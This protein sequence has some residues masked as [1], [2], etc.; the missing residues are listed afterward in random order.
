MEQQVREL[1]EAGGRLI[2]AGI[3]AAPSGGGWLV[4]AL[5]VGPR[6]PAPADVRA[7]ETALRTRLGQPVELSIWA[8]IDGVVSAQRY[9]SLE[10]TRRA[11]RPLAPGPG[12]GDTRRREGAAPR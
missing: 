12:T 10:S 4:R 8:Q 2:V 7:V 5:T 6:V 11:L 3:D 9:S 1:I